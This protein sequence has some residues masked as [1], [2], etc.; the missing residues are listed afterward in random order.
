MIQKLQTFFHTDKI[1]GELTFVFFTYFMYVIIGY[2]IIPF[3][4]IFFQGFNFGG[5]FLLFLLFIFIPAISYLIPV[6]FFRS[7]KINKIFLYC[8]HTVF[9]IVIPFLF[10]LLLLSGISPNFF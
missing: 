6:R 1:W 4:I 10:I 7:L 3:I 2:I 9:V 5:A 8:F